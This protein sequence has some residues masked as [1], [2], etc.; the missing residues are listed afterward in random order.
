M[1]STAVSVLFVLG[2]DAGFV[3]ALCVGGDC[4]EGACAEKYSA[5]EVKRDAPIRRNLIFMETPNPNQRTPS[6]K[7]ATLTGG[8][9]IRRSKNVS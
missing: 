1:P 6:P 3:V 5:K 4:V 8:Q 7:P 9:E 2:F